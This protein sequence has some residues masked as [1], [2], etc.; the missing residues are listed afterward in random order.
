MASA[1]AGDVQALTAKL[2]GKGLDDAQVAESLRGMGYSRRDAEAAA[3]ITPATTQRPASSAPAPAGGAGG[4]GDR[5]TSGA[6]P[7][8]GPSIASIA[9]PDL[10]SP[11]LKLPRRL[12]GGDVA[13]FAAGLLLYTL[14]LNY[15]RYGPSGVTGWM[16]AKFLNQV[17]SGPTLGGSSW[18]RQTL[19]PGLTSTRPTT[20]EA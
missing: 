8:G 19:S 3:G 18:G 9:V 2:R 13:G 6:T 5:S 10:P 11:T 7:P 20:R 16:R 17:P 14:A 4:A 15:I 12:D 1:S